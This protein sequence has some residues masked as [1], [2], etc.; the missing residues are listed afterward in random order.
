MLQCFDTLLI[1]NCLFKWHKMNNNMQYLSLLASVQQ[2]RKWNLKQNTL[3]KVSS[4][5]CGEQKKVK[6]AGSPKRPMSAYMRWESESRGRILG[7]Q[8]LKSPRRLEKC[9]NSWAKTAKRWNKVTHHSNQKV[10][11]AA[12][13]S[14]PA[15]VSIN[16]KSCKP[17]PAFLI[18]VTK[19]HGMFRCMNTWSCKNRASALK[20]KHF[21]TLAFN[22]L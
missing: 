14:F 6:E 10:L 7:Y 18:I 5:L 12:V 15:S 17:P 11:A 13:N 3:L 1:C 19:C 20:Q 16:R 9:G 2:F 22:A 8:S 21:F 4:S